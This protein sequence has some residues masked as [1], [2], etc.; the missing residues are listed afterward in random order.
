MANSSSSFKISFVGG[1][2]IKPAAPV[3]LTISS[4]EEYSKEEI[5]NIG[6]S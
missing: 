4:I 6:I 3:S 2:D 5:N 1:F